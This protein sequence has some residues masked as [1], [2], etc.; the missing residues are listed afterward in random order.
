MSVS[1]QD[2]GARSRLSLRSGRPQDAPEPGAVPAG[3]QARCVRHGNASFTM[4]E[5]LF[6]LGVI[7][8]MIG[9]AL[10][11][12][13]LM[14]THKGAEG[15]ARMLSRQLFLC[16]DFAVIK[17]Q[18]VALLLP[19]GPQMTDKLY[20]NSYGSPATNYGTAVRPCLVTRNGAF[21]D[22]I[23]KTAWVIMPRGVFIEVPGALTTV[24][25]GV[26]A[27]TANVTA[28]IFQP[29]GSLTVA[30]DVGASAADAF[31]VC[32]HDTTITPAANG[33]KQR[34]RLRVNWLTGR[35]TFEQ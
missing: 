23:D 7:A 10:G 4:V 32:A 30:S 18:R 21:V 13:N 3:P 27:S 1:Q 26:P 15:G 31:A 35:T 2:L 11:A 25:S 29:N 33:H 16:R 9:A 8:V 14:G 24:V 17:R 34:Y 12:I 28:V 5:M 20:N 19:Q 22:W 6:V